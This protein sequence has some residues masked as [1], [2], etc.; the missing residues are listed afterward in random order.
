MNNFSGYF[1]PKVRGVYYT[2]FFLATCIAIFGKTWSKLTNKHFCFKLLHRNSFW[3]AC[4]FLNFFLLLWTYFC[5]KFVKFSYEHHLVFALNT[6]CK[7]CFETLC[8]CIFWGDKKWIKNWNVKFSLNLA[9]RKSKKST[10]IAYE[11]CPPPLLSPEFLCW[12]SGGVYYTQLIVII[13]II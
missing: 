9:V 12:K 8:K 6:V 1:S 4:F 13:I 11:R 3:D 2:H 10:C 7:L 5:W